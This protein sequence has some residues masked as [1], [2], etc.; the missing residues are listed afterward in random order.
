MRME[1]IENIAGVGTPDVFLLSDRTGRLHPVELK[2]VEKWPTRITTRVLGNEGLNQ[3][4]KNWHLDYNQRGGTS[5]IL[6]G[7]NLDTFLF[8]GRTHDQINEFTFYGFQEY[9]LCHGWSSISKY[10]REFDEN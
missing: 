7:V 10:L 9:S 6:V 3:D 2:Q 8:H 4:Q 1:R 5:F